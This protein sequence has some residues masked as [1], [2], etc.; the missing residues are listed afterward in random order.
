MAAGEGCAAWNADKTCKETKAEAEARIKAEG[1]K[2]ANEERRRQKAEEERQAAENAPPAASPT[3]TPTATPTPTPPKAGSPDEI[4]DVDLPL[5]AMS[6][7]R[8]RVRIPRKDVPRGGT[9]IEKQ[10]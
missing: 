7:K 2:R 4:V 10:T 5:G 8:K 9:I 1:Q 3:A 6:S